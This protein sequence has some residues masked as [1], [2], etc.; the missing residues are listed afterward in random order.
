[1]ANWL[2]RF[3]KPKVDTDPGAPFAHVKG[4]LFDPG[5]ELYAYV[6]KNADPTFLTGVFVGPK[7]HF[8]PLEVTVGSP[9]VWKDLSLP[10]SP[11]QGYIYGGL[12]FA[13]LIDPSEYPNVEQDYN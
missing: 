2:S 12:E 7:F 10:Q 13:G 9:Q 6:P 8:T 3:L 1:M 4:I 11:L 5:A